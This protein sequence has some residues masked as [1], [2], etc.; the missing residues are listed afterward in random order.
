MNIKRLQVDV[1]LSDITN[2]DIPNN[3]FQLICKTFRIKRPKPT[4]KYELLKLYVSMIRNSTSDEI[5][6]SKKGTTR[7]NLLMTYKLNK[8]FIKFHIELNKFK[9]PY[10]SHYNMEVLRLLDLEKPSKR[11]KT[12]TVSTSDQSDP[13]IDEI[14]DNTYNVNPISRHHLDDGIEEDN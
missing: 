1:K 7:D 11:N 8:E 6:I 9:S 3:E 13:F 14:D 4:N 5:I 2:Y 10:L 12:Q